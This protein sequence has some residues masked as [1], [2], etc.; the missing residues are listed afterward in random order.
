MASII[1]AE[2]S[3]DIKEALDAVAMKTGGY[4]VKQQSY[5][6]T[7]VSFYPG[8][9]FGTERLKSNG[10]EDAD[11]TF[12]GASLPIG[13]EFAVGINSKVI[14]SVGLFVQVLDLGAVLNY[15]LSNDNDDVSTS[16][17]FGFKQVLSPGAY[18][19]THFKNNPITLGIGASYSP[20]LREVTSNGIT[21]SANVL[22]YGV[23]LAVDLNVFT[24]FGSRKKLPL[25][26]TSKYKAYED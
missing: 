21:T 16:S 24:I 17:D 6:S 5:F 18:L 12:V 26:S 13:V 3:D 9:E 22:Q 2:D 4:M 8:I 14:G 7:T 20:S 23:F 19:T 25:S 1:L 10:V 11:G 15:S